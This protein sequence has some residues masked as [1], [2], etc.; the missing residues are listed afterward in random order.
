[1]RTTADC[2]LS[3]FRPNLSD[4]EDVLQETCVVL[5]EKFDDFT[6]GTNFL[7]WACRIAH[8]KVLKF[9]ERQYR[10]P[11][12]FSDATLDAIAADAVQMTQQLDARHQALA[13]CMKKLAKKDQ[14]MLRR[15]YQKGAAPADVASQLGRSVSAIYKSLSRIHDAL[16]DCI[17][18]KTAEERVS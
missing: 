11:L 7:A 16:F 6:P 17:Q 2:T 14:D 1:L 9:L 13:E 4:A 18:R 10:G 5:W 3:L 12:R 8:F 15:R